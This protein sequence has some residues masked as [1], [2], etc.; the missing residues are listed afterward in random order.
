[1]SNIEK[2]VYLPAL[3]DLLRS[4]RLGLTSL[5]RPASAGLTH[6]HFLRPRI[7]IT[8]LSKDSRMNENFLLGFFSSPPFN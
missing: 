1:M 3:A 8:V 6:C 4:E 2:W 5:R 7:D